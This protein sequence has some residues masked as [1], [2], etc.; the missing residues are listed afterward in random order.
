VENTYSSGYWYPWSLVYKPIDIWNG[1]VNDTTLQEPQKIT[2]VK[3]PVQ[4]VVIIDRFTYHSKIV[5]ATNLDFNGNA[6]TKKRKDIY[7][8]AGFADGHSA[9][10]SVFEMYDSDVNWTGRFNLANPAT[11]TKGRAGILWKDFE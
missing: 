2:Q 11:Y 9:Y 4:K 1:A 7:V 6:N 5:V 8:C 10:R 3:Y